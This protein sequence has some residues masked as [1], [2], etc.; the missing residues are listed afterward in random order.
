MRFVCLLG[1]W[2][3]WQKSFAQDIIAPVEVKGYPYK[4]YAV[5][6][7]TWQADSLMLTQNAGNLVSE[8]LMRYSGVYLK[9]YG[10]AM[11]GTTAFRG[12][13]AGH[14][15]VLWNGININSATLGESDL[16]TLPAFA[17]QNLILQMGSASALFGSEAI[18][19]TIHLTNTLQNIKNQLLFRQEIGSFG[20]NFTGLRLNQ[21]QGNWQVQGNFYRFSLQN[22]YKIPALL[23][24]IENNTPV[25]YF[26]TNQDFSIQLPNNQKLTLHNWL[27]SNFRRLNNGAILLEKNWRVAGTWAK[28]LPQNWLLEA[29][30]AY[31]NDFMLYNRQDTTQTRRWVGIAQVQKD[32]E[33]I[34]VQAGLQTQYF[35]MN[36]DA[37]GEAKNELRND[38]F[39][40]TRMQVLPAWVF[41]FNAR[42]VWVKGY[43]TPFSP[44]LGS[45]WYFLRKND[46]TLLWKV[47]VSRGYRLPTLNSR[48]WQPGGNPNIL[49]EHSWNYETGLVWERKTS[50]ITFQTEITGYAMQVRDW[51]IWQPTDQGFWSPQNLQ[52][53]LSKGFE[54]SAHSTWQINSNFKWQNWFNYTYNYA[55]IEQIRNDVTNR[56]KGKIL[57]YAPRHRWS[58]TM[59]FGYK[60]QN[61]LFTTHLTDKRFTD[62]ENVQFVKA[63]WVSDVQWSKNWQ[64]FG[65]LLQVSLQV[66][67][68]FNRSYENILNQFMPKRNYQA[69]IN[70]ILR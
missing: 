19:G 6:T 15:A 32:F 58:A 41:V 8:Y 24:E 51:I 25:N 43:K 33:K 22:N 44:A 18:G 3:L 26:G 11:L 37:Y 66:N 54:I 23:G 29:K 20:R 16:A 61:L 21:N 69:G 9:E 64:W 46:Y 5:G 35:L 60:T 67:N 13:S 56:F 70:L 12:T 7:K 31:I 42:Q 49:P 38:I 65:N 53:V 57:P 62:L 39:C 4:R 10:N 30:V 17:H 59:A 2:L 55:Q 27:H 63:F 14:T 40:L 1:I 52:N 28:N 36:V 47:Q 50:K 68:I 48:Y 34:S 45:E